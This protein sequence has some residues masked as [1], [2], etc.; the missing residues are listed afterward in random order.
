MKK[1]INF[2]ELIV[3][4][5]NNNFYKKFNRENIEKWQKLYRRE[6]PT[7][8]FSTFELKNKS[9]EEIIKHPYYTELIETL[10]KIT[11]TEHKKIS[12]CLVGYPNM[13]KQ[14]IIDLIKNLHLKAFKTSVDGLY[15]V[16]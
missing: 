5:K 16:K 11:E 4:K 7:L 15:E 1:L 6:Q 8:L 14:S 13:G 12:V 10:R 9:T 2:R 3:F